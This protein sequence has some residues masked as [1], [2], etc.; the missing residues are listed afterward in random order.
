MKNKKR[1]LFFFIFL[2][3]ILLSLYFNSFNYKPIWDS[4]L[5]IERNSLLFNKVSPMEAFKYGYWE[6]LGYNK[7]IKDYYR[8][9]TIATLILNSR[10]FGR[11]NYSAYRIINLLIFFFSTL[12]LFFFLKELNIK[13]GFAEITTLLFAVYPLHTDN[14]VW[15]VGRCDLLMLFGGFGCLLYFER[16]LKNKKYGFLILSLLFFL[17]GI[18]SKEAFLFFFPFFLI[19]N[20][21]RNKKINF[22]FHSSTLL[23]ILFFMLI[24]FF[25]NGFGEVKPIFFH[26]LFKNFLYLFG[27]IG[28][29]FKSIVFPFN[30]EMFTTAEHILKPLYYFLGLLFFLFIIY[31]IKL[32]IKKDTNYCFGLVF[33]I[34]FFPFYL[35]LIF[36][37][38]FPYSISIRY[39]ILPGL[40]CLIILSLL[41]INLKNKIKYY[42][43]T[44]IILF[45][46]IST[47]INSYSYKNIETFWSKIYNKEPDSSF[48][49][50]EYARALMKKNKYINAEYILNR[51]LHTRMKVDTAIFIGILYANIEYKKTKY[52]EAIIWLEKIE[53]LPLDNLSKK[54]DRSLKVDIFTATGDFKRGEKILKNAIMKNPFQK[55]FYYKLFD[56]YLGYE[57]WEKAKNL[58]IN[59]HDIFQNRINIELIKKRF[60][61]YNLQE[62]IYYFIKYK[63]YKKAIEIYLKIKKQSIKDDFF[64]AELFYRSGDEKAGDKIIKNL[65]NRYKDNYK[66][67]NTLGLFYLNRFYRVEEALKY[68]KLSLSLNKNQNQLKSHI[69]YLKTITDTTIE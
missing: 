47:I 37:N 58:A 65:F 2:L 68:F 55:I 63:N 41:I 62:K 32:I 66:I 43:L 14:I 13:Q 46:Y 3:M 29:Y 9:F 56:I 44:P 51:A 21:F 42:I 52:N 4:K 31:I 39:M 57:E 7:G 8:P 11:T 54:E 48:I 64:L 34:S 30:L 67:L 69:K 25:V 45:F 12:F 28:Y 59:H 10:L 23:I 5:Q 1:N 18:F 35:A 6:P 24:K 38:L 53:K 17:I 33:I 26:P 27:G 22:L 50:A 49:T 61:S 40:G 36:T 15:I 19:Y 20:V 16:F 60:D